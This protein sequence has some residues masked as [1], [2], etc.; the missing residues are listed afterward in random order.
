MPTINQLPSIDEISGGNQIPTYYAGGGDARKMSVNLLQDY[1]QDN[2]TIPDNA[3]EVTYNPAGTGAVARTV[4]A[5]LRETVSVLDFGAD[6]TGVAD[7]SS[8]FSAAIAAADNVFIPAGTYRCTIV[9]SGLTAKT[10]RGAGRYSTFLKNASAS[11]VI[12]M[13]NTA[14]PTQ[15]NRICDLALVN[16]N[17]STYPNTDGI[18]LSGIEANQHE[19][20]NFENLW[21]QDFRRGVSITGRLIWTNFSNIHFVSCV[22]GVQA[23]S[24]HNVSQ[25][26][27]RNCRFGS[28]TE[29]GVYAE[30]TANDSFGAWHFDACTF[31]LNG[32]NGF[33]S[34]G[35]VGFSGLKFTACY[36][37]ENAGSI[38]AGSTN[39][40]KAN[41]FI[42]SAQCIGLAVDACALYGHGTSTLDWNIYV[43]SAT[44]SGRIGPNRTGT[45]TNGFANLPAGFFV[46]PQD[47]NTNGLTLAA[48]S[49]DARQTEVSSTATMT[50]TGCTT[51]PTGTARFV[52]QNKIVTAYF[53]AISGTSNTTSATLTGLPAALY[54]TRDQTV[55]CLTRDGTVGLVVA[56]AT[57]GVSGVI[58]LFSDAGGGGFASS[59]TKGILLQTLSWSIE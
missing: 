25:L 47:G 53:P 16:A 42:D 38:T 48:G 55:P 10:L 15:L 24:D 26:A 22:N 36:F 9:L 54:P 18:S 13:D 32:Q 34:A 29:Y 57:I 4:E 17:E 58:T 6:P 33:R 41:I 44:A 11:P 31:E 1:L 28:N 50:L 5:K 45:A 37:E 49:F 39:P 46:D 30:K 2:L 19:W 8:A 35:A 21:I 20:H 59:G 27:F 43:S 52:R 12:T 3:S 14:A 56:T 51:S 7:S 23:V 40:R